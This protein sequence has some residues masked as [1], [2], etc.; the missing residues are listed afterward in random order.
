[1][2]F[3][4]DKIRTAFFGLIIASVV[5]VQL[6]R[7]K[8]SADPKP[9]SKEHPALRDNGNKSEGSVIDSAITEFN[10]TKLERGNINIMTS[11]VIVLVELVQLAF[12]KRKKT[13][14]NNRVLRSLV[15]N[16]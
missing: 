5:L 13:K 15:S 12:C 16:T 2:N 9:T 7:A 1:M 14:Q 3:A 6:V 8:P 10:D 4:K 11:R